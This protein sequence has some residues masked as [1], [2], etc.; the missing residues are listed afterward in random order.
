VADSGEVLLEVDGG[1]AIVTLNAS[2]RR[3][4][5]TPGI[6]DGLIATAGQVRVPTITAVRRSSVCAGAAYRLTGYGI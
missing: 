1:V 4:L 5:L 2:A 6:A 3:D